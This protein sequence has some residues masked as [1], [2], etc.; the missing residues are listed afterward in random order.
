[1]WNK[2]KPSLTRCEEARKSGTLL[3]RCWAGSAGSTEFSEAGIKLTRFEDTRKGELN[4]GSLNLAVCDDWPSK[5]GHDLTSL[6]RIR[7]N[8]ILTRQSG[9]TERDKVLSTVRL[10]RTRL[11]KALG[12]CKTW[13]NSEGSSE[14]PAAKAIGTPYR[15]QS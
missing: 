3:R 9:W 7:K 13:K 11:R 8:D 14:A 1:V 10:D 4:L 2:V 5:V 12:R 15:S 6:N